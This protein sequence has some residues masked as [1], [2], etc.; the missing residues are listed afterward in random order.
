MALA[1]WLYTDSCDPQGGTDQLASASCLLS[2]RVMAS[3]TKKTQP[4]SEREPGTRTNREAVDPERK[5][6]SHSRIVRPE[7]EKY[8][9]QAPPEDVD[10]GPP[11]DDVD[12]GA[13]VSNEERQRREDE[14]ARTDEGF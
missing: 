2:D 12:F 5:K 9:G 10:G 3:S 8:T 13:E 4:D 11:K 14:L 6:R 7:S 1:G